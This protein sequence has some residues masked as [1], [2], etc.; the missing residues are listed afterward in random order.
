MI[1]LTDFDGAFQRRFVCLTL[2]R[3]CYNLNYKELKNDKLL[4]LFEIISSIDVIRVQ[5]HLQDD[6]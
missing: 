6:L 3:S 4:F 5:D 2:C 1:R